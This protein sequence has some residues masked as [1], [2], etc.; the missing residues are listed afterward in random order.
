LDALCAAELRHSHAD[1]GGA[2]TF[3][4]NSTNGKLKFRV[5]YRGPQ[6]RV[7]GSAAIVRFR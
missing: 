7:V 1:A 2:A 5:E 4:A 3:I 6:I